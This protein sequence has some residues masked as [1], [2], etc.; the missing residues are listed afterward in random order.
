MRS[1]LL[2][3]GGLQRPSLQRPGG[4]RQVGEVADGAVRHGG[5]EV[6]VGRVQTTARP[7]RGAAGLAVQQLLGV[8]VGA[9]ILR[10]EG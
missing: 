6:T 1:N 8:A 3:V 4:V 7:G 2:Q 10:G 5:H 9:F